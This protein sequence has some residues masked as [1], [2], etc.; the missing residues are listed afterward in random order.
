[1]SRKRKHHKAS[2]TLPVANSA[3]LPGHADA[4]LG[5][6]RYKDAIEHYKELLK[7][8]RRSAWLEGLAAAYAG[9]AAQLAAKGLVKE[10][11]ALWH[12]RAEVCGA[13]VVEGPYVGWL[14]Q[15]GEAEQALRLLAGAAK[16]PPEAQ[17]QLETQLAGA[18]LVAP[19]S[20]L[21]GLPPDSPL[22]RHRAAAQ[23]ALAACVGGDDAAMA[24]HLQAIPFRSPYRD[25]RSILKALALHNTDLEQAAAA[26]ARVPADGPFEPLAAALR[27]CVLPGQEWVAA[28]R[29]L[30]EAGR[31]L[32]LD[33]KG[34]PEERRA[35]LLELAKLSDGPVAAAVLCDL[36]VRY[37][38]ALGEGTAAQLC[39]RLLP[40]TPERQKA[41]TARFGSLPDAEHQRILA[42]AAELKRRPEQ[43]EDHWLRLVQCLNADPAE[44]RRAALVLRRLADDPR[45]GGGHGA[46]C[47]HALDWWAQSL[48]LDPEDRATHLKLIRALR[49]RSDLKETRARLD[50]ALARFPKDAEVLLEAVETALASGAFKEAAQLAKRLLQ[51]DPIN[52]RV[53]AVV[54]HAHLSHARKQIERRNPGAARR[55]LEEAAQWLRAVADC[56]LIKLLRGLIDERAEEGDALLREGLAD[57]GGTLVGSFH[58]LLE[59]W[60]TKRNPKA[61]L[62]RAGVDLS[63]APPAE[64]VVAL[65]H[66]LNAASDGDK[67]LRAALSPLRA[68]L[69]RAAA[70]QF[71]EPDQLLVC[72][73]LHRRNERDLARRYAEGALQRWP[74]RPV[75]VYLKAAAAY[76]ANP[77]QMPQ[78]ELSALQ[79]ALEEAQSHGDQRTALRLRELLSA[80]MGDF[81]LPG[82]DEHDDL[83][84]LAGDLPRILEMM[85]AL[86]GEAHFLDIAR[87][88]LGKDVFDQLRRELG[89][90]KKQFARALMDLLASVALPPGPGGPGANGDAPSVPER[91]PRRGRRRPPPEVQ[92]DLFDD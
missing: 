26:L 25:L 15:A 76:G 23:A 80:T 52:S 31:A 73:A 66:A 58:L 90:N 35:L 21:S 45:H 65:A 78:R 63:A 50:Q 5:A 53:R 42:L 69:G 3:A 20:A 88:Q 48:V 30:D 24:E 43:A 62:R 56:G 47:E 67:A 14:L 16:L 46:A 17:A 86:G 54:G 7:H 34:C 37:R 1:M 89:G 2:S 33:V 68:M 40:H 91:P 55:E 32:V 12:T 6:S 18:V 27:A 82:E 4:A 11:L 28:L 70:A 75:F 84:E 36:L 29:N 51:L 79:Q 60:R 41:Y 38:R 10:A 61:L 72:E 22:L 85:L 49:S 19:D 74:G 81:G 83:D 57:L 8:E 39:R 9:R 92:K 59:A 77:W 71:A 44:R 64:E 87:Q 13:P